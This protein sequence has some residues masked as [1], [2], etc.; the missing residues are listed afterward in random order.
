M[1]QLHKRFTDEQIKVLFQLYCQGLLRRDTV[2]EILRIGKSQLFVLLKR[3]RQDP[4]SF[5]VSYHRA[6]STTKKIPSIRFEKARSAGNSLFRSFSLPKPYTPSKD[7]FCLRET[8]MV[9]GYRQISLFNHKIEVP[10]VPLREYV[11]IH[12]V[13]DITRDVMDIR[14]WW[15]NRMVQSVSYPLKGFRVHF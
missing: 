10:N 7:I 5:S 14:I 2:Q 9:N 8:R 12:L 1:D 13:P 15:N 6:H 11:E 3:Y 4:E